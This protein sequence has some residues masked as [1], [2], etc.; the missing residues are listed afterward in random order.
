MTRWL[1]VLLGLTGALAG[2]SPPADPDVP[3]L[4][5]STVVLPVRKTWVG[6]DFPDA[7]RRAEI[8]GR[9]VLR[10]AIR[11]DGTVG[12]T[13]LLASSHSLFSEAAVECVRQWKYEPASSN[14]EPIAVWFTINVVFRLAGMPDEAMLPMQTYSEEALVAC[15]GTA[16]PSR[17]EPYDT[18]A[19][20][21]SGE[22]LEGKGL[23]GQVTVTFDICRDGS[24]RGGMIEGTTDLRL[25]SPA[26]ATV[27]KWRFR[28]ATRDGA[29]V[30]ST[31]RVTF[32][33]RRPRNSR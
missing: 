4:P 1:G 29:P 31:G 18:P 11:R 17:V 23:R 15:Y 14:G 20:R 2:G 9:V 22:E 21:I 12:E 16:D 25:S 19:E 6:P 3:I 13:E 7:L 30:A 27:R 24:V 28:P 33:V 10:A 5:D 26:I 32:D 8:G